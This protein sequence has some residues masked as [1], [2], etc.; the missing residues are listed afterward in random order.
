[1]GVVVALA[2]PLAMMG[3]RACERA[4]GRKKT[5]TLDIV[6]TRGDNF[7]FP[8]A[9]GGTRLCVCVWYHF[10]GRSVTADKAG[11]FIACADD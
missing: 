7:F 6:F 11:K 8:D 9:E 10:V 4:S 5:R 1:M 3:Y 2:V